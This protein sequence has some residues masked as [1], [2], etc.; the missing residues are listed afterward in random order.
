MSTTL[1]AP[2][3]RRRRARPIRWIAL[4]AGAVLIVGLGIMF[5]LRL[6]QGVQPAETPLLGKPAPGFDL[7]GLQGGR[8]RLAD[9]PGHVIVVNFWASWC[10]PCREEAP[11]LESFAQRHANDGVTVIGIV[12]ND[13][14]EAAGAFR[15][16]FELTFPQAIDGQG[17]ASLEYGVRGVPETFVI[18]PDGLV[19]A[20]LVGAVGPSTLD[21]LLADALAGRTR[22]ERNDDDY[23][24]EP[25]D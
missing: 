24:T 9:Y 15:S 23:R 8:I 25:P 3:E 5:G 10:V 22:S 2:R 4:T 20:K 14:R 17:Q 1:T 13:T 19:M 7:S 18:T 12:W 16:E 21:D 6:E 11:R